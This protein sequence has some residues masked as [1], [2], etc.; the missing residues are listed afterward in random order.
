MTG[1]DLEQAEHDVGGGSRGQLGQDLGGVVGEQLRQHDRRHLRMLVAEIVG[2]RLGLDRRH[3]FPGIALRRPADLLDDGVDKLVAPDQHR[4]QQALRRLVG[5]DD[6]AA[7]GRA[8]AEVAEHRFDDGRI[9]LAQARHRARDRAD[10]VLV[11]MIHQL[12]DLLLL[13]TEEQ[14]GGPLGAAQAFGVRR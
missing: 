13:Q 6:D 1:G 8:V 10:L 9:D 4:A 14:D 3:A 12:G 5:A 11:Q 7:A 2:Q